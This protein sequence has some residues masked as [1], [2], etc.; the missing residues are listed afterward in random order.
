MLK[1]KY[2]KYKNKIYF[3]IIKQCIKGTTP[4]FLE[5]GSFYNSLELN[6]WVLPF[7]NPFSQTPGLAVALLA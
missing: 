6:S 3:K 5:I 7:L 2:K 4:L 1:Y